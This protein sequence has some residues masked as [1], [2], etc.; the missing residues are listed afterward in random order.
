MP[1]CMRAPPEAMKRTKGVLR[2]T[3]ARIAAMIASPAA[4][5]SEP[6]MKAKSC[7]AMVDRQAVERAGAGED[8][9]RRRR[10]SGAASLR[11]SA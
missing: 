10:S 2:C 9:S 6:P 11:R 4:M 1:S 8:G 7:T 5:P 3:A